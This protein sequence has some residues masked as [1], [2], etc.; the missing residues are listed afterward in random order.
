MS[1]GEANRLL[2]QLNQKA[3]EINEIYTALQI[4][5]KYGVNV[6]LP[7]LSSLLSC[8]AETISTDSLSIR[9]DDFFDFSNTEAAEQYLIKVGHAMPLVDIHKALVA[10]GKKFKGDGMKSLNIQ[11]TRATKKFVRMGSGQGVSFGLLDF[12]PKRKKARELIN[13]VEGIKQNGE[14]ENKSEN[15]DQSTQKE[16][17]K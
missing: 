9:P 11:L 7:E 5:K 16:E 14:K 1:D 10:G 12:Y 17:I 4:M 6:D 2:E 15:D 8:K 13:L 3:K